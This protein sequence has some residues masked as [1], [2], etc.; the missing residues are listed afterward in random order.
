MKEGVTVM[1]ANWSQVQLEKYNEL[2]SLAGEVWSGT[3]T[4]TQED[5]VQMANSAYANNELTVPQYYRV[6]DEI[7]C[8]SR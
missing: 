7:Y 8:P 1:V 3:T 5:L 4:V 6:L 2:L